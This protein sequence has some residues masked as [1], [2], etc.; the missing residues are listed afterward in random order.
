MTR[1][2]S[3]SISRRRF[4]AGFFSSVTG[5]ALGSAFG[6][7]FSQQSAGGGAEVKDPY[8]GFRVGLQSYSLRKFGAEEAAAMIEQLG[9][10]YVE[11]YPAHLPSRKDII[12]DAKAVLKRHGLKVVAYGVVHLRKDEKA[13]RSLFEFAKEMGIEVL[14]ADP[15]PDSFPLLDKLTEE[16]GILIGIHNHGPGHRWSTIEVMHRAIKD[17]SER[18]GICLDTGHM[19]RAND[20][21]IK[22][23]QVFGE[24]LHGVHL[25]D[26]NERKQDVIVGM[27]ILDIKGFFKALKG[28]GFKGYIA[29]EYELEP[30][31]P[32]PGIRKSLE[33]IQKVC[34]EL[35]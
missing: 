27:G 22:A 32:L 21:I 6:F 18:I 2:P 4:I 11:A 14:S 33:F 12:A 23:V 26:V 5:A 3:D 34:A 20:D 10:K 25:K 31:N 30:D 28:I 9:L 24:R 7:M 16:Y 17:Y 15:D 8:H 13:L 1:H 35:A 19:A 29:L